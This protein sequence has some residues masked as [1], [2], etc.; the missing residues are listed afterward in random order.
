[1]VME[2]ADVLGKDMEIRERRE[3]IVEIDAVIPY[4][5]VVGNL[6]PPLDGLDKF[7]SG[8]IFPQSHLPVAVNVTKHYIHVRKRFHMLRRLHGIEICQS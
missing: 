8:S 4:E 6:A 7:A 3:I 2:K 5:D 1:M